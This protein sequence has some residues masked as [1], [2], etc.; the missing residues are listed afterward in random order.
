MPHF[1]NKGKRQDKTYRFKI[2]HFPKIRSHKGRPLFP[3]QLFPRMGITYN[4]LLPVIRW[5]GRLYGLSRVISRLFLRCPPIPWRHYQRAPL[6]IKK[7]S[8]HTHSSQQHI[9]VRTP[10]PSDS[11]TANSRPHSRLAFFFSLHKSVR[12]GRCSCAGCRE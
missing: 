8:K 2:N 7:K 12:C 11:N 5:E 3:M 10:S 6:K 9:A 1:R 4:R